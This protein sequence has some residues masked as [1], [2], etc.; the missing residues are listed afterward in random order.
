[1][2]GVE[3]RILPAGVEADKI[4]E[5]TAEVP[6]TRVGAE[7][8]RVDDEEAGVMRVDAEE[9]GVMR[10]DAEEA[11]ETRVDAEEAGVTRVGC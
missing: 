9:A 3:E 4:D 7:V 2:C 5:T 10:V 6:G 8:T 11:G 1:M